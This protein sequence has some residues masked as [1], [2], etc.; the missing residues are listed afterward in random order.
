MNYGFNADKSLP[1]KREK[2]NKVFKV[3]AKKGKPT[4]GW[5]YGFK[6]HL[7]VNDKGELIAFK[8]TAGNVDDRAPVVDLTKELIGKLIADK[9]YIS[10]N[11]TEA[12]LQKG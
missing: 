5:F 1:Y 6:L 7:I 3:L 12:L 10:Q 8:L 2:Q 9:G 11:L 4:I